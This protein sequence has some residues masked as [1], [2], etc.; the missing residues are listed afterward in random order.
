MQL[1]LSL[2]SSK[3]KGENKMNSLLLFGILD[4][5]FVLATTS[6]VPRDRKDIL[7][8]SIV[9]SVLEAYY[10][11]MDDSINSKAMREAWRDL[12]WSESKGYKKFFIYD[13]YWNIF[14]KRQSHIGFVVMDK[15]CNESI[16]LVVK[17]AAWNISGS[18]LRIDLVRSLDL[19]D[20][21]LMH[22]KLI[23]SLLVDAKTATIIG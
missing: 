22:E 16:H 17:I 18:I 2:A 23:A 15:D 5:L 1:W 11:E 7:L 4:A 8:R 20:A 19:E 14:T 13:M 10:I 9:T 12:V 3:L 6:Y 21:A